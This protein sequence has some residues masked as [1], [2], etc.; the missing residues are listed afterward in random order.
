[1][2]AVNTRLRTTI[3]GAGIASLVAAGLMGIAPAA[4]AQSDADLIVDYAFSNESGTILADQ[5]GAGNDGVLIGPELWH[6]GYLEL[7]GSNYVELPDGLLSDTDAA[8][9]VVETLPTKLSGPRFLW[10]FGGSGNDATG[11]FFMHP[12]D[13]RVSISPTNY[14]SEQTAK[15]DDR[16]AV[17]EWSSIAAT[18]EPNAEGDTSTL[19]LWVDGEITAEK[20]DSSVNLRDLEDH[21]MNFLGKSAYKEDLLYEGLVT[22]FQVYNSALSGSELA[23][24]SEQNA[25]QAAAATLEALDLSEHND[26]DLQAISSDLTLPTDA[27]ISWSATPAVID[28]TGKI[29]PEASN[30][31]VTLT[32]TIEVRGQSATR[33]FEVRVGQAPTLEERA[34]RDLDALVIANADDIRANIYLPEVGTIEGSIFSWSSSD[35]EIVATTQS[36][37]QAP[38]RVTRPASGDAVVELEVVADY[39]GARASRIIEL[40]VRERVDAPVTTDYLFAHFINTEG[41]PSDEQIYFATSRDGI[42]Y[43]D[44]REDGDPVL[45]LEQGQ[46]DGGVRDPF[47]IRS[48]EGDRFYLIATDLNIHLRGGWG[49]A[50]ATET[51]STKLV[52]WEST[53]LVNWSEPR[54]PDVAGKIPNAGMAWAP[55]A[56]WD[57]KTGQYYVYWATRADGNTEYGDSVDVYLATTRDFIHFSDPIKWIDREHSIIDTT[58]IQVGD[59]YYRAS[60]DGEITIERSKNIDAVTAAPGP[61]TEGRDDEWVLV[62]TLQNILDG[63]GD[64]AGGRNYTGACLEGPEFFK[65][66]DV[67]A[68]D[69]EDQWVLI[70]DQY[71]M[72]RGYT[73][74]LSTDLSST[75][76]EDWTHFD[77]DFGALKKRHGGVLP[78]TSA[79]YD[80]IMQAYAG[81]EPELFPDITV[82]SD[83]RCLAGNIS[84]VVRVANDSD[85]NVSLSIDSPWGQREISEVIPGRTGTAP[86][87]TRK[88]S[89]DADTTTVTLERG[90]DSKSIEIETYSFTC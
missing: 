61:L 80:R 31:N 38:G 82:T 71:A 25:Q 33:D 84:Q 79:E 54:F 66:N 42:N 75:S 11:Q 59:W 9:V 36:D 56:F 20:T 81:V 4:Q 68:P 74:F 64:C 27:G 53:D 62:D 41:K 1:M 88:S 65:L 22:S 83:M 67:D 17:D 77:M 10:N 29:S 7:N 48:G 21:T 13:N 86:I 12:V 51:G 2:R 72:G 30:T 14:S 40:T 43:V 60:G 5:S 47:L 18:I 35:E 87:A 73:G 63:S 37:G 52:I 69:G 6:G 32:A 78:I 39:Q 15:S 34:Q 16:L 24:I 45:S 8:T 49:A 76:S 57:E 19:R 90:E 23:A 50:Q 58:M 28:E 89:V 44:T 85:T 55:E 70:A 46:G 26:Q 3:A